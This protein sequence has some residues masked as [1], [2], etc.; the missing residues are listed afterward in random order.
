MKSVTSL[1]KN[2]NKQNFMGKLILFG[3][4]KNKGGRCHGNKLLK[5]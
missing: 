1:F 5:M 4:I 2:Q 3:V